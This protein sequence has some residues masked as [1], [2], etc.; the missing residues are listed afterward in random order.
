[1]MA[2]TMFPAPIY[3]SYGAAIGSLQSPGVPSGLLISLNG[4][5]RTLREASEAGIRMPFAEKL[6]DRLLEA[7]ALDLAHEDFSIALARTARAGSE[8]RDAGPV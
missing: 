6:R 5:G 1:M 7:E 8:K 2:E 4:V 3:R